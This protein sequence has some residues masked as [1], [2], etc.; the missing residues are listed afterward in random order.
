MGKMHSCDF[1]C[2]FA[3]LFS[4]VCESVGGGG[5]NGLGRSITFTKD[6][7]FTSCTNEMNILSYNLIIFIKVD[8]IKK[9][10]FCG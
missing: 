8:Q 9:I 5:V 10:Y 1:F 7:I 2:R 3:R 4:C 6:G